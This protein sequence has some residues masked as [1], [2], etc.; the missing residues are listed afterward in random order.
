MVLYQVAEMV[1]RTKSSNSTDLSWGLKIS[2]ETLICNP[3]WIGPGDYPPGE[4]QNI[5]TLGKLLLLHQWF[6]TV[7][8]YFKEPGCSFRGPCVCQGIRNKV[9]HLCIGLCPNPTAIWGA[10]GLGSAHKAESVLMVVMLQ[11]SSWLSSEI[12]LL[13]QNFYRYHYLERKDGDLLCCSGLAWSQLLDEHVKSSQQGA[14]T[15]TSREY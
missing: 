8:K 10:S 1:Y 7:V 13:L 9:G 11:P 5:H 12:H 2:M 15:H 3:T 4:W 6:C 14:G